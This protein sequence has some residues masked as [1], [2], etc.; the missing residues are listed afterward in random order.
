MSSL[1]HLSCRNDPQEASTDGVSNIG[2]SARCRRIP[3][4][5]HGD[6]PKGRGQAERG[7][8]RPGEGHLKTIINT[9]LHRDHIAG[10]GI[11]DEKT[12]TIDI[13]NLEQMVADGI[14]VAGSGPIKGRS[15]LSFEKYYTLRFDGEEVRQSLPRGS[16]QDADMLVHFTRSGVVHMGDLLILQSFPSVTRKAEE[17]LELLEKVVDVFRVDSVHLWSRARGD[18]CR[19]CG[20]P[21][22]A[23]RCG[24]DHQE[25][26]GGGEDQAGH[27]EG[28]GAPAL[29]RLG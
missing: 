23:V 29:R 16:I 4:G 20:V 17:Y 14:L 11:A 6:Q 2:R 25:L 10:N 22:G 24:Q 21:P 18:C 27:P 13:N 28:E 7:D 15:G 19:R 3:A 26:A 1:E 12:V 5:G 8:A 9:H